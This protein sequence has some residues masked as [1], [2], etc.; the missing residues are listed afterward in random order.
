MELILPTLY[1]FGLVLFRAAGLCITAPLLGLSTVPS[2]VR[3]AAAGAIAFAGSSASGMPPVDLPSSLLNLVAQVFAQTMIGLAAGFAARI[4]LE[5]AMAAGQLASLSM[6]LGYGALLD[7]VNGA[8]STAIGQL[9][10]LAAL[11][12]AVAAGIHREAI[13]WFCQSLVVVPVDSPLDWAALCQGVVVQ[14][15][16][17]CALTVRLAFP[18][19]VAIT[20]GHGVMALMGRAAPQVNVSSVGF[21]VTIIAG[22]GALYLLIPDLAAAAAQRAIEAFSSA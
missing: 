4:C 8:E 15:I 14:I 16:G 7:P 13:G 17:S 1:G 11:G 9:M 21:S 20:F 3:I 19:L 2:T 6:G 18:L 10:H 12:L 5:G 22:G